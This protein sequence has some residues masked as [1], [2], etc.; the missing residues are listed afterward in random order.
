VQLLQPLALQVVTPQLRVLQV[1]PKLRQ[2]TMWLR[3]PQRRKPLALQ[4]ATPQQGLQVAH[5]L[6]RDLM[7]QPL[8]PQRKPLAQWVATPQLRGLQVVPL[9]L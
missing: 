3:Q 4:V 6:L 9:L 1:A 7:W 5:L 8:A 2:V